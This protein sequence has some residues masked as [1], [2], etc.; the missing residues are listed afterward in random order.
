MQII[1]IDTLFLLNTLVDYLLLLASARVA[2]EPLYRLRFLLGAVVGGLYAVSIFLFPFL[3]APM[4]KLLLYLLIILLAFGRS[5]R[6]LRQSLI[7]LALTFAFAGGILAISLLGGQGLTFSNGVLYSPMDL[8]MVLLSAAGCYGLLTL[9]FRNF[10]KHSAVTGE[11]LTL[12][13]ILKHD[14]LNFPVLLDTGNT[15]TDPITGHSVPVVEANLVTPFFPANFSTTQFSNP[16]LCLQALAGTSLEK[17]VRLLPYKAVGVQG[18]LLALRV[19][20]L[21]L[22]G[23]PQKE[24]LVAISPTTLSDGGNY[25]GLIG[26]TYT[27]QSTYPSKINHK[28]EYNT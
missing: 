16:I 10:G 15:L 9:L 12:T 11:L 8:K 25:H 6:L 7:F 28:M 26:D 4:Y 2:G 20:A 14:T 19:D 13:L 17:R 22:E 18:L 27:K 1:Y 21:Q 3:Q 24:T 23:I 5:R